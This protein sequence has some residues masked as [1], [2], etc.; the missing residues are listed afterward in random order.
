MKGLRLALV[1]AAVALA[2]FAVGWAFRAY[3][4]PQ[5]VMDYVNQRF[6]CN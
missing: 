1:V 5:A 4:A 2:S 3:L 6:F